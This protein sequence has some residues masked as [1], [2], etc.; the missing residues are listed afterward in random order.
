MFDKCNGDHVET[1]VE[2]VKAPDIVCA[3]LNVC[4]DWKYGS[5]NDSTDQD[6]LDLCD[7]FTGGILGKQF[8]Y[9]GEWSYDGSFILHNLSVEE[10]DILGNNEVVSMGEMSVGI[11][12]NLINDRN[13]A[14]K[15]FEDKLKSYSNIY[16]VGDNII[17]RAEALRFEL[18]V[19]LGAENG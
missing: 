4:E 11:I 12:K 16:T 10:A 7:Y 15:F 3:V 17:A 18:A 9:Y 8:E 6:V 5:K 2:W 19:K 13:E 1:Y 14:S